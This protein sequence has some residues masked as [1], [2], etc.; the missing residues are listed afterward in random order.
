MT[1]VT[2]VQVP[3]QLVLGIV[4][5][6]RYADIACALGELVQYAMAHGATL[7]GMPIALFHEPDKE[8]MMQADRDGTALIDVAFPVAQAVKGSDAV[9][10][11]ELPGGTMA[12]IVHKGPYE[13]S[14]Q[15]YTVLFEWLAE[16]GK[17]VTGPV[18]EAYLNDPREVS[19]ED[20]LTEI[21]APV[22]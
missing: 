5:R 15:T 18:R 4:R 1:D 8:T 20:I 3:A 11:Y 21:Y 7:S 14:E 2:I 13:A 10:C 16:H 17:K 19:P 9:K 12:K 6:G 22:D